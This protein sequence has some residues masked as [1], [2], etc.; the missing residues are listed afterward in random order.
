MTD[1]FDNGPLPLRRL[2][3]SARRDSADGD[4]ID[5]SLLARGLWA[6][7][8]IIIGMTLLCGLIAFALVSQVTPRYRSMAQV[9]LDPR[10]RPVMG[11]EQAQP[12]VKLNDEV[13][14]SEISILQSNV[15]LKG[16][17]DRID[18]EHPGSLSAIDPAAAGPGLVQRAREA[19][20]GPP[21][22][23]PEAAAQAEDARRE[24]LVWAIRKSLQIWREGDAYVIAIQAE[25]VDPVLSEI[26]ASAVTDE[27]FAQQ[28]E[29]RRTSSAEAAKWIEQRVDELRHQV[30]TAEDAVEDYRSK[31]VSANGA[32]AEIISRRMVSLNDEM[33]AARVEHVAAR[34]R[35]DEVERLIRDGGFERLGSMFSSEAI[36]DLTQRRLDILARDAQWAERF[37]EDHPER[38]RMARDLEEVDRALRAEFMRALDALRN[39]AQIAGIREDTLRE[40][41]E[42]AEAQ[43]LDVSRDSIGLRQLERQ[44]EAARKLYTQLLDRYAETRT[45]EL[46]EQS[47]ARII[48]R[49]TVAGA[50]SAPRPKLM[51]LIGLTLGALTGFGIVGF[52][53]FNARLYRTP[54]ELAQ[55]TGLPVLTAVP[56]RDWTT[57]AQAIREVD[58]EPMGPLAESVRKLRNDLSLMDIE[59]DPQSLAILSPLANEG[60]TTTTVLLARLT[61]MADKLVVIVDCDFRKNSIQNEYRF[62]MEHDLADLVR[63]EC[64]VLDAVQTDTDL[65][66]DLLA[67][68]QSE[69]E[70]ADMLTTRWLADTVEELKQYYDLVLVNCPAVL[71]VAETLVLARAVD[72]RVMLVRHK[73]T[74]RA[75][76]RRAL[77]MLAQ[78]G[79]DVDGHV[80]TRID[81]AEIQD[82]YLYAYDI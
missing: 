59:A 58:T 35:Y 34:A 14:A 82:D 15:L 40:S 75:A 30:E 4:R 74:P 76:I 44:A 45:R 52:R 60:K 53:Q 29:S 55:D 43:Y 79:L 63:G 50:P 70:L 25:T 41:L 24:R 20:F 32:S 37:D 71:P 7:R 5:L 81:P 80:L 12:D 23:D 61:E 49:P 16:V 62:P 9:L 3:A 28:L 69:P 68:R 39:E 1:I 26:L 31:S 8:L 38:V 10:E 46:L 47:G 36:D 2:G 18:A 66:F 42:A 65:G 48:E 27:Y 17:I 56:E 73:Q 77:S 72:R 57:T 19:V 13:L 11:S 21:E 51:T 33:I 67:A 22:A 6:D 78:H 64:G 54:A